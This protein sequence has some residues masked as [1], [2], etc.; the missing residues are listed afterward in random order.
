MVKFVRI[1]CSTPELAMVGTS[2]IYR[3]LSILWRLP[4]SQKPP[5]K[6]TNMAMENPQFEDVFIVFPIEHGDIG[7]FPASPSFRSS[8]FFSYVNA[9][10]TSEEP[11]PKT[12]KAPVTKDHSLR[13]C[14]EVAGVNKNG[15][16]FG[17]DQT[18][19]KSMAFVGGGMV[20]PLFWGIGLKWW[21]RKSCRWKL[22]WKLNSKTLGLV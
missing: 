5:Q 18:W 8:G 21:P 20:K 22:V 3:Y 4:I 1:G 16:H 19:C 10:P 17:E 9:A 13:C 2:M 14:E 15:T 6:K 7:G 11:S 12:N